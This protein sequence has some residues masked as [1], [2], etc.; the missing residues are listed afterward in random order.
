MTKGFDKVSS[1]M[2]F[3]NDVVVKGWW[4]PVAGVVITVIFIV[5]DLFLEKY[6]RDR[7]GTYKE[8]HW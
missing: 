7:Y 5:M 2:D 4:S 1:Y 8:E 3:W 6:S